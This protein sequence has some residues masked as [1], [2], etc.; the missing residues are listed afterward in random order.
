MTHLGAMQLTTVTPAAD[1][2]LTL[3][4]AQ[5]HLRFF[6]DDQAP[7]MLRKLGAAT[8]Y[9]QRDVAGR[10]QFM[11]ATFDGTLPEFPWLSSNI[12]IP[13]PPLKSATSVKYFDVDNVEQTLSSTAYSTITP[14]ETPGFIEVVF[15]ETWPTT[16]VRSD[17]VMVR[18]VAGYD[19]RAVIPDGIKEAILLKLE[20]L[21]HPGRVKE[22]DMTRAIHDLMNHYEYGHYE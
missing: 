16:Y 21:W 14:T 17:A 8:E 15:G 12:D 5:E 7:D 13:M 22:S 19:S 20:H 2:P 18:F 6:D 4:D 1:L 9:C 10:R 3:R 11:P